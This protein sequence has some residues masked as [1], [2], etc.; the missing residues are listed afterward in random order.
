MYTGRFV[1]GPLVSESAAS[2]TGPY[3]QSD[4]VWDNI[5]NVISGVVVHGK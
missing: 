2:R 3:F 5:M 1:V 4:G